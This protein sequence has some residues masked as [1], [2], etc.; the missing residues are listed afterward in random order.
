[1][2][3]SQIEWTWV[4]WCTAKPTHLATPVLSISP[5]PSLLFPQPLTSSLH[6]CSFHPALTSSYLPA[7]RCDLNSPHV[8]NTLLVWVLSLAR[9]ERNYQRCA[10]LNVLAPAL[11]NNP[12]NMEILLIAPP[13]RLYI[14]PVFSYTLKAALFSQ[15]AYKSFLLDA[16]WQLL[17]S[18]MALNLTTTFS[19]LKRLIP[20]KPIMCSLTRSLISFQDNI[21]VVLKCRDLFGLLGASCSAKE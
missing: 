3:S 8:C 11:W 14:L 13:N 19:N 9:G 6:V 18:T 17:T 21:S 20:I 4:H 12:I 5:L 10:A 1:M 2:L 15:A 7:R 16:N